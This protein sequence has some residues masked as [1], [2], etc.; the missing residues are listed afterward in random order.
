MVCLQTT[1]LE[2]IQESGDTI[3]VPSGWHHQVYNLVC[4]SPL[5]SLYRPVTLFQCMS[6]NV[7]QEDTISINHNWLNAYNLACVVR[8][9]LLVYKENC[10]RTKRL[11]THCLFEFQWDLLWKDYKDTEESI[12]DIRDISDDFEALCQRNLAAN[13]GTFITYLYLY[14][15]S[16]PDLSVAL[17]G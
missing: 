1:W 11:S 16:F 15:I 2:C 12:E 7:L 5:L 14:L 4:F 13:T 8:P 10:Y 9:F 6:L 3:F 17:P